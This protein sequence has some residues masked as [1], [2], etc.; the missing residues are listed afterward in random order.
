MPNM[1]PNKNPNC[2]GGHCRRP[3]GET[4]LLPTGGDGNAILCLS[5]FCYEMEWRQQRNKALDPDCKF[6]LPDWESLKISHEAT[7]EPLRNLPGPAPIKL[8]G[9]RVVVDFNPAGMESEPDSPSGGMD[10]LRLPPAP[11]LA[12]LR[13]LVIHRDGRPLALLES[14]SEAHFYIQNRGHANGGR[15]VRLPGPEITTAKTAKD[16]A[17]LGDLVGLLQ[18]QAVDAKTCLAKLH[19]TPRGQKERLNYARAWLDASLARLTATAKAL[20]MELKP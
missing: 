16:C 2:D 19:A 4:R 18:S 11:D 3:N 20:R 1:N 13:W 12:A 6:K 9:R 17:T 7:P 15:Y 5:C 10:G 14:E 8:S